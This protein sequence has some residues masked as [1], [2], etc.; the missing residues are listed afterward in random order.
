M[1]KHRPTGSGRLSHN[2]QAHGGN[3]S[4]G[5]G[6][7][8]GNGAASKRSG[9]N[10]SNGNGHAESA[11][12]PTRTHLSDVELDKF[13]RMLLEKRA[14]LV[15]DVTHMEN[16]ALGKNRSDASG[17]LSLMPIHMADIGTD[18]Y[19]QEFTLGLV[20][21]ERDVVR[22]IDA[23]LARI[24]QGTFGICLATLKPIAKTRLQIKP[25]ACYCVEYERSQES[26]GK[27]RI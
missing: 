7:S 4:S 20:A 27:R 10:G 25:W 12:V 6:T 13:R 8:G 21:N 23:A 5:N 2:E 22:E 17:D 3:G 15:G 11:D 18:N 16:E 24:E 26:N 9:S 19:E 1:K 14:E